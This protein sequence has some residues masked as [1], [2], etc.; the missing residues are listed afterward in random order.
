MDDARTATI[1]PHPA[2][3][4]TPPAEPTTQLWLLLGIL[5]VFGGSS[6]SG[7]RVAV[8]TAPPTIVAAGRLWI[9]MLVLFAYMKATGRGML[10][11]RDEDGQFSRA[12]RYAIGIG[13]AGYTIP[14]FLFPFAQQNVSSLL[15]GIYMAFMPVMTVFLAALFADEPLTRRKLVG[16]AAGTLGVII[17][18]GPYALAGIFTE[19]VIAQLALVLAT[20]GYAVASVIMRNAP[21]APARS[22]G[23][24]F[25][26]CGALAATPFALAD[27]DK[28]G[29][30]SPASWL[31]IL[32][33]GIVPT[34][35]TA[36]MIIHLVR[37][38]GAGFLA[39]GNYLTPGAAIV[40]GVALFGETLEWRY[41][42]GL[43]VI[44]TGV[45]VAQRGPLELMRSWRRAN[46]RPVDRA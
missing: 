37:G 2:P 40:F 44:L 5:I 7:I 39:L 35:I 20:T 11:L 14:M 8:E 3:P 28:V 41:L 21:Q 9:G 43:L 13:L 30:V 27:L 46:A 25:M 15:A 10:P 24:A 22:F 16:F 4:R 23:V 32:Y 36:I 6:F 12:W 45:A 26:L 42:A 17:L 38:A 1:P 18:I 19:S 33:L 29:A 31:A 34:G